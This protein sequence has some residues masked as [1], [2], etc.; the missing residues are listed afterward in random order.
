MK[1][2]DLSPEARAAWINLPHA[3]TIAERI[4]RQLEILRVLDG[5]GSKRLN[6]LI[7]DLRNKLEPWVE[8]ADP[9]KAAEAA[10]PILGVARELVNAIVDEERARSDRLGQCVRNLF[11]CLGLPNE[12]RRV[13]LSCGEY[14]DSLMR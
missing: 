7:L 11:E 6:A 2:D 1:K 4:E 8:D 5:E 13:S 9:E 10:D 3:R 12:G 14:P